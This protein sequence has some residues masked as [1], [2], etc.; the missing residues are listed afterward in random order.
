[1]DNYDAS[2]CLNLNSD[3]ANSSQCSLFDIPY[4][5]TGNVYHG[6][7]LSPIYFARYFAE[8]WLLQ[9]LSNVSSWAFGMLSFPE[10]RDLEELETQTMIFGSNH[11]LCSNDIFK[12]PVC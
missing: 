12:V 11:W 6:M 3:S 9:Y 8:L 7:F 1:M 10:L 2:V 4:S 5:F